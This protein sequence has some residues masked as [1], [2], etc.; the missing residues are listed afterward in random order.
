MV[1]K[2]KKDIVKTLIAIT[3]VSLLCYMIGFMVW[4]VLY[5]ETGN[6]DNVEHIHSTWLISQGKIPYKDFFQHHN[7]LL[8]Y[9]FAPL[10]GKI[11]NQM[12]LL[13]LAHI[14]GMLG[15]VLTLI[16]VYKICI[17]FFASKL[18]SVLSILVLCPPYFYIYLL[19]RYGSTIIALPFTLATSGYIGFSES[20]EIAIISPIFNISG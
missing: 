20:G 11:T 15:G 12:L 7:P 16:F 3:S 8:W 5:T 19:F 17:E 2:I 14:L 18:A 13:D 1:E 6:G 9:I 10:I 4:T